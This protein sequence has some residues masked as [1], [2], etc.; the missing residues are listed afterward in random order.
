MPAP[1]R[2]VA[3]DPRDLAGVL[4]SIDEIGGVLD[5]AEQATALR[6][7]LEGRLASLRRMLEGR[8]RPRVAVLEWP[9]PL[10]APGHWVPE[11][12]DAAGGE[13]VFGAAGAPSRPAS[14]AEL[15]AGR[16]EVIVLAFC[17]FDLHE[18]Q[19]RLRE[20][21]SSPGWLEASRS[22]RVVAV[23]GSAFFSRPGPRVV[24]GIGL[25]SWALHRVHPEGRPLVGGA[26]ELIEA[27]WIDLASL[28][29]SADQRTA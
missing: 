12:V 1:A 15:A 11:M 19:A 24:D 5:A 28:P 25:L 2:V 3:T 4:A 29:A 16:P 22:A 14:F 26:A 7:R 21:A 20:L 27:G 6:R 17:G 10:Y 13:S 18:T 8:P 23:D 9:D